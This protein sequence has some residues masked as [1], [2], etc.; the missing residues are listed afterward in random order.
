MRVSLPTHRRRHRVALRSPG[1][2]L[3]FR[4]TSDQYLLLHLGLLLDLAFICL[5]FHSFAAPTPLSK[6]RAGRRRFPKK[7]PD[8][9]IRDRHATCTHK[10]RQTGGILRLQD[11][12]R[13]LSVIRNDFRKK[14]CPAFGSMGT[15]PIWSVD[16]FMY[17]HHYHL[18]SRLFDSD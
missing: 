1:S 18:H 8:T 2:A 13:K 10:S 5:Q 3:S 12:F 17:W 6:A 16:S 15:E 9:S 7:E 14:S 11:I 4:T